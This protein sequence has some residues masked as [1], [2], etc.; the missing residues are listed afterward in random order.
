MSNDQIV[1]RHMLVITLDHIEQAKLDAGEYV[2][3]EHVDSRSYGTKCMAT[4][5]CGGWIE[6]RESHEVDGKKA[7]C[8][9]Y[10]CDCGGEDGPSCLGETEADYAPWYDREEFEFHGVEHTWRYG[11]GWTVPYTG[12]IVAWGDY[13]LPD[14]S[15]DL[16]RG[17]YQVDDDWDDTDCYLLL[18]ASQLPPDH[19]A[20]MT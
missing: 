2:F 17:E 9:P 15:E 4:N 8:G 16:P 13:E 18:V 3:P 10:D 6:C 12:C 20:C 1:C 19:P 11:H 7:D 5:G 14:G